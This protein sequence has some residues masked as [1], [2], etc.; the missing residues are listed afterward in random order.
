MPDAFSY[1]RFSSP[2]QAQGDSIRRQAHNRKAWPDAHPNVT[3]DTS[4]VMTDAGTPAPG[5]T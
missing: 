4:L 1:L 5:G 2:K 3:F